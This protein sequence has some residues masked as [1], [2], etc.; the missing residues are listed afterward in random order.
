MFATLVSISSYE[1]CFVYSVDLV[2]LVSSIHTALYKACY[3]MLRE[4]LAELQG[5]R[6]NGNLK[7]RLPAYQILGLCIHSHLLLEE[8]FLMMAGKVTDLWVW[9]NIIGTHSIDFIYL[10]CFIKA[11]CVWLFPI[12]PMSLGYLVSSSEPSKQDEVGAPTPIVGLRLS[13]PLVDYSPKF[14][15]LS[16]SF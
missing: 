14:Y 1:S 5:W 10:F 15:C 6:T 12:Y 16:T 3:P 13:H 9:Q 4:S 2:L 11:S 7:F 8:A